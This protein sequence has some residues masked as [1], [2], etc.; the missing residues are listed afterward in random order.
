MIT[1][2]NKIFELIT[3]INTAFIDNAHVVQQQNQRTKEAANCTWFFT[4]LPGFASIL[5]MSLQHF[6]ENI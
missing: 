1:N 4:Q 6:K 2:H 3:I 5:N